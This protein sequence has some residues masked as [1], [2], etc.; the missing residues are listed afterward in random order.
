MTDFI[1]RIVEWNDIANVPKDQASQ[2]LYVNLIKEEL[3]EMTDAMDIHD[4]VETA[5]GAVDLVWVL[6]GYLR[7]CG[8]DVEGLFNEVDTSNYSKFIYDAKTDTYHCIKNEAGKI[9]KPL[10]FKKP[11]LKP[12]ISVDVPVHIKWS[13]E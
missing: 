3:K 4:V 9:Q 8:H 7:A 13:E 2:K 6:V 5:D 10:G 1:K 11:D 12:H